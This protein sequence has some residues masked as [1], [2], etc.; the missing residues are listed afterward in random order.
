MEIKNQKGFI[1]FELHQGMSIMFPNSAEFTDAI[2]E[3]GFAEPIKQINEIIDKLLP[4]VERGSGEKT[5]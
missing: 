1:V 4:T 5:S 2:I 3:G